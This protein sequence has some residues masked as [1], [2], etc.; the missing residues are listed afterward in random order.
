M[1]GPCHFHTFNFTTFSSIRNMENIFAQYEA[2]VTG[3]GQFIFS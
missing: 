1:H 3:V 2:P